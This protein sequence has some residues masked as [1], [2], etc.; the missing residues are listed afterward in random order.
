MTM[1]INRIGGALT[2]AICILN[3]TCANAETF[4]VPLPGDPGPGASQAF[5][6][7]NYGAINPQPLPPREGTGASQVLNS[8]NYGALNPQPLPPKNATGASKVFNSLNYGALNPQPLPPRI[9]SKSETINAGMRNAIGR[10]NSVDRGTL[11]KTLS[12]LG[13]PAS[14]TEG[15]Q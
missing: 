1:T 9:M 5:N 2:C 4:H 15:L 12:K 10:N 11:I 3:I 13:F 6:S 14:A 7:L 8:L